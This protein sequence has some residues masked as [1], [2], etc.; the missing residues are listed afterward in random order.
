VVIREGRGSV[1]LLQRSLG[2]GYGRAAR[3][4]DF[5]AEDGIVGDYKGSQAR[6]VVITLEDWAKMSG[7]EPPAEEVKAPPKRRNKIVVEKDTVPSKRA[8]R[9]SVAE[10]VDVDEDLSGNNDN[11]SDEQNETSLDIVDEAPVKRTKRIQDAD[12]WSE[13]DEDE[14]TDDELDEDESDDE[15]DEDEDDSDDEE[16]DDEENDSDEGEIELVEDPKHRARRL[17]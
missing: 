1:S 5:M 15:S 4:I 10:V 14:N 2:I 13:E 12:E 9:R 8:P 6:E 11:D 7:Q 16:S 3:L 17:R